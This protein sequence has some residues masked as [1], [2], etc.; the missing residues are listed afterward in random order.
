MIGLAAIYLEF[1][2]PGIGLPALVAVIAFSLLF[3]SQS[4]AHLTGWE[5]Y[6]LLGIGI[7]LLGVELFVIPGFGLTG[8]TGIILIL[9]SLL[10]L[11]IE[12]P[13]PLPY[14]RENTF[15]VW[16]DIVGAVSVLG[17]GLAGAIVLIAGLVLILPRTA[18][19]RGGV[20]L[21]ASEQASQGYVSL[22]FDRT[23]LIGR[24][25]ITRGTLRPA[26]V[27]EIDGERIDVVTA[28]EWI[29]AGR[30]VRIVRQEGRRIIVHPCEEEQ[31]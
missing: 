29:P 4:V 31:A 12:H 3:W 16:Q 5:V 22:P 28:G 1:Q 17:A 2:A 24:V 8:I 30:K 11:L 7:I 21:Q 15:F 25:G 19:V 6:L 14:F 18:L 27:V 13:I 20:V 23:E 10:L 26:G 9:L